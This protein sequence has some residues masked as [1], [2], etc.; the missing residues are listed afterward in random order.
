VHCL[1]NSDTCSTI[2]VICNYSV[3]VGVCVQHISWTV[4]PNKI[5]VF[6]MYC[7]TTRLND[8]VVTLQDISLRLL[9]SENS[10]YQYVPYATVSAQS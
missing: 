5:N 3:F 8:I 10:K 7:L 1:R 9:V 4:T 6:K 2:R